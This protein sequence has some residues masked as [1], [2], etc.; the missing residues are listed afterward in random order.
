MAELDFSKVNYEAYLDEKSQEIQQSL[1]DAVKDL[2]DVQLAIRKLREKH[3]T[4]VYNIKHYKAAL[5]PHKRLPTDVLRKIFTQY[6]RV[7]RKTR[8]HEIK[9]GT[10]QLVLLHVCSSWRQVALSTGELWSNVFVRLDGSCSDPRTLDIAKI[11][12]KRAGSFPVYLQLY[13]YTRCKVGLTTILKKLC[14]NVQITCF[15]LDMSIDRLNELSAPLADLL[16]HVKEVRLRTDLFADTQPSPLPSFIRHTRFLSC[17]SPVV[18]CHLNVSKFSLP[19]DQIRHL[20][21][22]YSDM[23]VSQYLD[24]LRHMVSLE[25]CCLPLIELRDDNLAAD[26][27]D[28]FMLPQ[29]RI[30]ILFSGHQ[31]RFR[32]TEVFNKLVRT[33]TAPGLRKLSIQ[34]QVTLDAEAATILATRLNL[35]QLKELELHELRTDGVPVDILLQNA[36]S[37]RR[38]TFPPSTELDKETISGL[39]TGRVGS[40]LEFV[41]IPHSHDAKEILDMVETRQQN[42]K[43]IKEGP[44]GTRDACTSESMTSPFKEVWFSSP[45]NHKQWAERIATLN[46]MGVSIVVNGHRFARKS[47]LAGD[48]SVSEESGYFL[49]EASDYDTWS[50]LARP[51]HIHYW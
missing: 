47:S 50:E 31:K 49:G 14:S 36:P 37:L 51:S 30:L 11:W 1:L 25:E 3:R 19:W 33:I 16:Q 32:A 27:Q 38:I 12:L 22:G 18:D 10:P 44:S 39:A 45:E 43:I 15:D 20:D 2:K 7:D 24:F 6:A 4:L 9:E 48:A 46:G 17:E 23:Q 5:A 29:L 41:E 8:I 26:Q 40:C 28:E 42:A 21:L 35:H 34:D 13:V